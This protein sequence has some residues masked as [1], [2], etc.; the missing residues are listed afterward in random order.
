M[1][2]KIALNRRLSRKAVAQIHRYLFDFGQGAHRVFWIGDRAYLETD[3][4]SDVTL[5]RDQFPTMVDAEVERS[6]HD[7]PW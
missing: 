5:L 6:S 4:A 7:F 3:C 2:T 1:F